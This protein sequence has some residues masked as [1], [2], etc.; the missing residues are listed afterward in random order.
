MAWS[1]VRVKTGT[2]PKL[3]D[4]MGGDT[5][6][7]KVEGCVRKIVADRHGE[8]AEVRFEPNGRW[9]RVLFSWES[10][11]DRLAIIF[12]LQAEDVQDLLSSDEM[13]ELRGGG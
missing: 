7:G 3:R 10:P 2:S 1:W 13:E 8:V 9:A 12:D 4:C 11:S 5:S 6:A